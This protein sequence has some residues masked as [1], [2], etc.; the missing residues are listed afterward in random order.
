L[1]GGL[2]IGKQLAAVNLVSAAWDAP[3]KS[4]TAAT[5][6]AAIATVTIFLNILWTSPF[7]FSCYVGMLAILPI[8]EQVYYGPFQSEA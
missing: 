6:V 2:P 8:L 4:P 7:L 1:D 5:V 3:D